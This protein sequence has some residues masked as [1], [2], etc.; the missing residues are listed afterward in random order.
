MLIAEDTHRED[1]RE[2]GAFPPH[3]IAG[4]GEEKTV[5]EILA[6]PWA[7]RF[8]VFPKP[9]VN[10][11]VGTNM[12]DRL[13]QMLDAG[14]ATFVVIGDC[15][16]LCV[17][18]AASFLRFSANARHVDARVIVP[19]FA[20]DTYDVPLETARSLGACSTPAS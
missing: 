16:D 9:T 13:S 10:I 2:F 11:S 19:A 4:S 7:D 5:E 8:E 15:T 6:L 18:Q 3:C 14:V 12:D 1:D 20:V 17:Y